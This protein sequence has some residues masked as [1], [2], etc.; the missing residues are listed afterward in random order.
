MTHSESRSEQL[1]APDQHLD[2]AIAAGYDRSAGAKFSTDEI[3]RTADALAV[4]ADGGAAIEFAIGTG[5]V[6]LPLTARGVS[7]SGMDIS[8][9]MLAELRKK[10]GSDA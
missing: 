5:R 8:E 9:P 2:P 7:V 10:P 6:A 4:L 1:A 3:D